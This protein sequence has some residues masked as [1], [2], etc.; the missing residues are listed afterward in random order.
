MEATTRQD[1]TIYKRVEGF[2]KKNHSSDRGEELIRICS[3]K[4]IFKV[5]Y[6]FEE[7]GLL[8]E[9]L[10]DVRYFQDEYWISNILYIVR[11]E[12]TI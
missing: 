4:K 10:H 6:G 2:W 7:F 8:R 12:D 11:Y 9:G 1:S 3:N 5:N